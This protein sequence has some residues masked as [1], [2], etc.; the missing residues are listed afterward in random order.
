[1]A[2]GDPEP[3]PGEPPAAGE[4]LP[5]QETLFP[6]ELLA[7]APQEVAGLPAER[8]PELAPELQAIL[9]R[10]AI[11]AGGSFA[12]ADLE[13]VVQ[14][15]KGLLLLGSAECGVRS[16][17]WGNRSPDIPHSAFRTPHSLRDLMD[18]GARRVERLRQVALRLRPLRAV[19]D[20]EQQALVESLS[21]PQVVLAADGQPAL[22]R[23]A[24]SISPGPPR[25]PLLP[26]PPGTPLLAL[27]AARD[28]LE[29]I[30]AWEGVARALTLR[31]TE[32][33][34]AAAGSVD[35][36]LAA[37]ALGA[38]LYGSVELG[39]AELS[40]LPRFAARYLTKA[41]RPRVTATRA[42]ERALLP[43]SAAHGL[44]LDTTRS[45]FGAGLERLAA[46]AAA[47]GRQGAVN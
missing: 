32:A 26:L 23:W 2:G 12:F 39:L 31:R 34:L 46:L 7:L 15:V 47:R 35:L 17:E 28:Q 41:G 20:G 38:V 43:W 10:E 16:A 42:L 40:D 1:V 44:D 37:L 8:R 45:L 19:L 18:R 27:E 4:D 22:A 5:P 29:R 3:G 30:V 33:A 13:P 9:L 14:R 25:P 6:P 21:L 36:L 11:A 24:E